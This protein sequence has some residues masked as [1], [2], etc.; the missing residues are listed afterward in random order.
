[1]KNIKVMN[2][3]PEVTDEEIKSLMNFDALLQ[4]H[5]NTSKKRSNGRFTTGM[6]AFL[7]VTIAS[8]IYWF[9]IRSENETTTTN[10][11]KAPSG[12]NK[13]SSNDPVVSVDSVNKESSRT[14]SLKKHEAKQS[15]KKLETD[16]SQK[17]NS[18]IAKDEEKGVEKIPASV[19]VQA[20]PIAGYPDLYEYFNRELTYPHS[21]VKDSVSGV[22]AVVFTINKEGHPEKIEIEQ[23]LGKEFDEE[24]IRVMQ[25]MPLWNPATYNGKPVTSRMSLPLTFQVRKVK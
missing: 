9:A 17:V 2:T 20:E 3:K 8:L 14:P 25:N 22:V 13:Q 15:I 12:E 11:E 1:M 4:Q 24:A 10:I 21:R 19:F 23:S 18:E 7:T 16:K 6:I 5:Q